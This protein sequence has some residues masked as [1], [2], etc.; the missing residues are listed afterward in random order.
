MFDTVAKITRFKGR[1]A[2]SE[3]ERTSQAMLAG[4]LHDLG[5]DAVVS[6]CVAPPP[7]P[8]ILALHAG[9]FLFAALIALPAPSLSVLLTA[10]ALLSF[11]GELRNRPRILQRLLLKR[12]TGNMVARQRNRNARAQIILVAH[13]DVATSSVLFLPWVKRFTLHREA[14]GKGLHPGSIVLLAGVVQAI[15]AVLLWD[16]GRL[17]VWPLVAIGAACLAH[18]GLLV[19]A[20]DWWR[21]PAVEGAIDNGSG[22]A[23]TLAASESL[24]D[25]PLE[26]CEL[27]VVATGAREPEAE[28]MQGF[29]RQ[30]GHLLEP[31]RTFVI[32]ID[33]V[34]QGTLHVVVAEGR[35]ERLSYRPTLPAL[36]E[37]VAADERFGGVTQVE[38]VGTTDAGPATRAGYR[39]V[40]LT[41]LVD[42]MRPEILHTHQDTLDAI[43]PAT[44]AEAL[45]FTMALCRSVDTYVGERLEPRPPRRSVTTP[46]TL[47]PLIP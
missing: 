16:G 2:G 3:A 34:G 13:A 21:S 19:L 36:A 42:G 43:D 5:M 25:E 8:M 18:G 32:N 9:V 35:W 15:S 20:V 29:V 22:M 24:T 7:L 10:I 27:W 46:G 37:Q 23:V 45:D 47:P 4:R 26:H 44:L 39:A 41:S 28:G 1:I 33:D 6:G 11:W 31:D 14:H 38:V 12:I 17:G 30:F 40:T